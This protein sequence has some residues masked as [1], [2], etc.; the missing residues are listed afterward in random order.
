MSEVDKMIHLLNE[1]DSS[2]FRTTHAAEEHLKEEGLDP[3]TIA[4]EISFKL[5]QT[6]ARLNR[7][8][9]KSQNSSRLAI[10][11]QLFE[12]KFKAQQTI[13]NPKEYF[14]AV[15]GTANP[16]EA[17]V[18]FSKLDNLSPEDAIASLNDEILL[19]LISEL[20]KKNA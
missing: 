16:T 2:L 18:F 13:K 4:K 9:A 11:L 15:L 1:L 6:V 7:Q 14:L 19:G 3:E 12:E 20:D 10:A 5:K 8:N 17:T